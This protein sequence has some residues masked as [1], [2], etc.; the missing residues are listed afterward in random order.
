V[1]KRAAKD[2][3][4]AGFATLAKALGNGHRA[5]IVDVLAQGERSVDE[6]S[7]EVEQSVANTSQH[8]QVLARAGLVRSRRQGTRV[9]YRLASDEVAALW[10]TLRHVGASHLAEVEVL[11]AAYLGDRG[12]I[13]LVSA[14]E[15]RARL[16]DGR[17]TVL[18]VRPRSEHAAGHIRGAVAAPLAELSSLVDTL[19]SGAEVVA[20]CRGPYCVYADDAVRVLR[21]RGIGARR[22]DTGFPEWRRAGYPVAVAG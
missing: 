15:L 13:E 12:D 9:V 21:S 20:Y 10:E 11:A 5:E 14:Q 19:P 6:L 18:D 1:A 4:Y 3:L 16:V 22:L 17:V 2:A 7:G 8:L